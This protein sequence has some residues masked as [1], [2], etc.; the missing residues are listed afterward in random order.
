MRVHFYIHT[1]IESIVFKFLRK[2]I[3]FKHETQKLGKNKS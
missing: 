3:L 1:F 2:I